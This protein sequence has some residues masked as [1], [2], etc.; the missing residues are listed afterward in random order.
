MCPIRDSCLIGDTLSFVCLE[1]FAVRI[2]R[3]NR[4]GELGYDIHVASEHGV[5]VYNKLLSIGTD[6]DVQ[7]AGFRA[8]N[9]LGCEKGIFFIVLPEKGLLCFRMPNDLSCYLRAFRHPFVG[10]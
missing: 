1:K 6:F 10:N 8:F 4:V 9:S 3:V 2:S 7:D 5:T